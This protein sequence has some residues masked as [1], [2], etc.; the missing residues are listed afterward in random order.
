MH[1]RKCPKIFR[2][3]ALSTSVCTCMSVNTAGC[4]C[5]KMKNDIRIGFKTD[6]SRTSMWKPPCQQ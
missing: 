3:A 2:P 6:D 5:Q 1:G 4:Q